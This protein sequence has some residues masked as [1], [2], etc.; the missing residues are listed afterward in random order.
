LGA[1]NSNWGTVRVSQ[2]KFAIEDAIEMHDFASLEAA[3]RV[4]NDIPLRCPLHLLLFALS[5]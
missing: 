1:N 5:L 3:M 2:Q 4:P